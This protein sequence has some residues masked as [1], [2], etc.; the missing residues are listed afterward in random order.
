MTPYRFKVKAFPNLRGN[1]KLSQAK[2]LDE[3][4]ETATLRGEALAKPRAPVD[5]GALRSRIHG[6]RLKPGVWALIAGTKYAAFVE[7][8]TGRLGR[9]SQQPGGVPKDYRHGP[10]SG[11]KAQPYLRPAAL[12]VRKELPRMARQVSR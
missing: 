2:G 5:E 9:S 1:I 4:L 11:M 6:R 8:G 7:F 12:Q 10:R 3:L